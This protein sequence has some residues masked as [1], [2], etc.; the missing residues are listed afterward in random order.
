MIRFQCPGCAKA[1]SAPDDKAGAAVACPQ[2]Q[3][4]LRVPAAVSSPTAV[5]VGDGV[6]NRT[7]LPESLP[8]IPG[9][10]ILGELGR[11]GMGVVYQ[12]RQTKV[13]RLVALKMILADRPTGLHER[14]RFQIE[15]EAVA[16]LRH[17]N[18]VQLYEIGDHND[19]PFFSLE[20]CDGGSL[21]QR[22]KSWKP[23]PRE[24]AALI[25]T[26][27]RAI[28]YAHL[29]GIVHRDLKP[30]NILLTA[31]GIPKITD[32]GLAKRTE[33]GHDLSQSG[34]ILGTAAYMAPEQALGKVRDTGPAAD[35]YA[36]GAILYELLTGRPP[37]SGGSTLEILTRVATEEPVPPSRCGARVPRDLETICL[38]CLEKEPGKRYASAEELADDLWCFLEGRPVQARPLGRLE[39]AW[40]WCRRNPA[41]AGLVTAVAASLLLGAGV[42]TVFAVQAQQKAEDERVARQAAEAAAAGERQARESTEKRLGQIKKANEILGSIF[43]DLDPRTAEKEGKALRVLLGERLD[44]AAEALD[45]EAVGDPLTMAHLQD[46]LGQSLLGLGYPERA[47][48]LYARA[49]QIFKAHLGPDHANTLGTLNNLAMAH[50]AA[51]QVERALPLLEQ[52]LEKRKATLGPDHP[53]TLY[54]LAN[55]ASAYQASGRVGRAVPLLEQVLEKRKATLPPDHLDILTSM[56]NLAG[57]YLAA[58]QP[59]RAVP[60]LELV[61]AKCQARYGPDHTRT[62]SGMHSLGMAYQATGQL[63]RALPLLEQTLEKCQATLG[64]NHPH[65]LAT[66]NVLGQA[67]Q[68]A[69]RFDRALSLLEQVREKLQAKFGPD[70]HD[71]VY[72]LSDLALAYLAAQQPDKAIPLFRSFVDARRKTV[73]PDDLG[74]AGQ[75][76]N[77]GRDVLRAGRPAAAEPFLRECLAIRHKKQPEHWMTF[78]TRSLLGDALLSQKKYAEAEPL[79]LQGWEGMKQREPTIPLN[80]RDRLVWALER[81]VR[82]YEATGK[83]DEVDKWRRQLDEIKKTAMPKLR[84]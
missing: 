28:H 1:L 48:V 5:T 41:V 67:Y 11:G 14:I 42:A 80:S 25:E 40:R 15:V 84:P 18:I 30:A 50:E 60:L 59:E 56:H 31:D 66:M 26:L 17:L 81:L 45:A 13:N 10:E 76:A 35:V 74:L 71:A 20:F 27:A 49:H 19:R 70:H 6:A 79:L 7:E 69:G 12:A 29:R 37:F 3:Q 63:D 21:A 36:L 58:S 23:G 62:L 38:K 24:A 39:R 64:P 54:S 32:F 46:T 73:G 65:T 33:G 83:K 52:I 72:S 53:S 78:N 34:A 61:L 16:H 43:R 75:L 51:G 47:V 44:H 8:S 82:L 4:A 2:C 77:I 55:L 57:A 68:A 9:Y 22:L